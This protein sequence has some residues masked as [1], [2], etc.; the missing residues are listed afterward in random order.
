MSDVKRVCLMY[1]FLMSDLNAVNP[2][3]RPLTFPLIRVQLSKKIRHSQISHQISIFMLLGSIPYEKIPVVLLT[4]KY[5]PRNSHAVPVSGW[6]ACSLCEW[7]Q[8]N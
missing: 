7:Y 6:K 1:D 5:A 8:N 4:H 3:P 2:F